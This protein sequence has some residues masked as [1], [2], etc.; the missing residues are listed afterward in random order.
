[1][2]SCKLRVSFKTLGCR[3]NQAETAT[4]AA[5]F[6]AAGYNIVP[7]GAQCD[8]AV[9]H[10][11]AV[12]RNAEK[13]SIRLAR[14]ARKR[15]SAPFVILAGCTASAPLTGAGAPGDDS[16]ASVSA[17]MLAP[18]NVKFSLPEILHSRFSIG[19]KPAPA[20][21]RLLP[22]FSAVRAR[23]KVQDGCDFKCAYC[24]VPAARGSSVSRPFREIVDE[25]AALGDAG[26]KEVVLTGA[27]LGCY[28]DGGRRL[29]HLLEAIHGLETIARIRLSSI[30][31]ETDER[32]II[33]FMAQSSKVCRHLHIP[34]QTGHDGLL[35]RMGR[36]HTIAGFRAVVDRALVKLGAVGLGTDLISG[37][38]GEDEAAFEATCRLVEELPFSNLHVF[39]Y[40]KRPGTRASSMSGQVP[41]A[42]KKA[43]VK[44][45]IK[46]GAAK[47]KTFA[48]GFVGR[49]V[50]V[51]I[52]R[53]EGTGRGTGWTSEYVRACVVG[54]EIE[55][56]RIVTGI[57][58]P[59]E[60][61][62]LKVEVLPQKACT[63]R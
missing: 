49:E 58:G 53:V 7:F 20:P 16:A 60:H 56:N 31:P 48:C 37:L 3:L 13:E 45:L 46:F 40:S 21:A 22:R 15:K 62:L 42:V 26:F 11:C 55:P 47:K 5:Q 54:P 28:M 39:P 12:T 38:P 29:V 10:G 6:E 43:R 14:A 57:A 18:Q 25:V 35:A 51:L 24:I 52:E 44:Q 9:V 17:D 36:T 61:G 32:Q 50:A 4:I 19:D 33:D 27:N 34:L 1:M 59:V 63:N 41:E 23:V 8:V 30:E 2:Q